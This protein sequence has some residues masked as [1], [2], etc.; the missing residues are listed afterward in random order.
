MTKKNPRIYVYKIIF[1]EVPHYYYGVHKEKKFNEEYWGS[2]VT[3][4]NYWEHYTP[5]KEIIKEFSY[6]DEDWIEAQNFEKELIKPVY[7]TDPL[8]LNESCGGMI[9]LKILRESGKKIGKKTYENKI[10][11]FSITPEQRSEISRKAGQKTYENE[12]GI[13]G[14]TPQQRSENSKKGGQKNKENGT[15]ICG[16]TFEQRRANGKKSGKI[17]GKKSAQQHKENGTWIYGLTHDQRSENGKKGGQKNKE[18][19]TGI[20]GLTFEQRSVNSKKA[21]QTNKKNKTGIYKLTSE[22]RSEIAKK[23]NSQRWQCTVTGYISTPGPLTIYQKKRGI[24]SSNRIK[25]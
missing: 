10:G 4:K 9:S 18:N 6:T 24:D 22:Q 15:G 7:N 17:G 21:A 11:W 25:I 20:C 16:L 2:P 8:C 14:M 13:F 23:T 12:T 19:G 1:L 5:I 3:H